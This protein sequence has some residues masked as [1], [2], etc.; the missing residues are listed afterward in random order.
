[1]RNHEKRVF[2]VGAGTDRRLRIE[3]LAEILKAGTSHRKNRLAR[4]N[5]A[6]FLS[7]IFLSEILTDD[8]HGSV[9]FLNQKE[10]R[11]IDDRKMRARKNEDFVDFVHLCAFA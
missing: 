9:D 3:G 10:D 8:L 7:E 5:R 1:V 6:I 2:E 11:K 4:D